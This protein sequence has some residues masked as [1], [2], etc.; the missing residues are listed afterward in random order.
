MK[1]KAPLLLSKY[2]S[3]AV[4]LFQYKFWVHILNPVKRGLN[5]E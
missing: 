4:A 2:E 1:R 3:N 5:S